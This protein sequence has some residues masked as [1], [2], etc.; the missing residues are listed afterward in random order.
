MIGRQGGRPKLPGTAR[1]VALARKLYEDSNTPVQDICRASAMVGLS[2]IVRVADLQ[3]SLI[4]RALDCGA[5]GVI[6]PRVESPELLERAVRLVHGV[7][8]DPQV[9]ADV[10]VPRLE[11]HSAQDTQAYKSQAEIADEWSR[12]PL[13]KLKAYAARHQIGDEQWADLEREAAW[14][15]EA[16]R[17][18]AEARGISSPEK[19]TANVFYEGELQQVGGLW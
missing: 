15:V 13:P 11:G 10:D 7:V 8:R 4:A 17:T 19:V 3:Y 14:Q 1:K 9:G 16:A 5:Q 12:D 2:P 18:E 6:F